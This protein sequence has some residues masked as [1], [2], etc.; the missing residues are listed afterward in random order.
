[1]ETKS[2]I[3]GEFDIDESC[4]EIGRTPLVCKLSPTI[5]IHQDVQLFTI[6]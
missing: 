1:M 3:G 6:Y 4:W 2:V 5:H